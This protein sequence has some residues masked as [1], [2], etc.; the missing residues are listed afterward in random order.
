MSAKHTLGPWET[1]G[2]TKVWAKRPGPDGGTIAMVTDLDGNTSSDF[3]E[4]RIS[5]P[6]FHEACANALLIAASPDLLTLAQH[7]AALNE[8]AGEI[9]PGMLVQLV[10]EARAAIAKATAP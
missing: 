6:R 7:V 1:V 8:K 3:R 9:G 10:N 2:A 4:L 5:S